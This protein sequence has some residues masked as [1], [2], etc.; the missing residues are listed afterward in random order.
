MTH[1]A[2]TLPLG[3]GPATKSDEFLEKFQ[4]GGVFFNPKLYIADFGKFKQA[5]FIM[6]LTQNS[7]FRVQGMFFQQLYWE[8]QNKTHFEEGTSE[9]IDISWPSY[10]LAYMQPYLS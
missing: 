2:S 6:K 1:K 7:N 10:L 9:S 3:K 5:F 8:K 4:G